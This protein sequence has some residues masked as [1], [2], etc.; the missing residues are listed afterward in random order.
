MPRTL[1]FSKEDI[2]KIAF[3]ILIEKGSKEI[4]ARNLAEK[5]GSSTISI[6]SNFSS[7][8]ELKNE[9]SKLAKNKLFQKVLINYTDIGLLNIGIGICLFAKE[10]K[11][12]FRAIFM[13]ENSSKEFQDELV[14]NLRSLVFDSFRNGSSYSF[15]EDET[16]E[17]MLKK[18]WWYVHGFAC[19]ICSGFYEPSYEMI[20][21]ELMENGSI[22][23]K[24]ALNFNK[25]L[26]K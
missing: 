16:I 18:G 7:M 17:W 26:K 19:L 3:D 8:G 4:T 14:N 24:E 11:A 20:E 25:N 2:L 15:F 13:R 6:Y 10:E 5:L 12:L 21:K 22:L 23:L 1:K 9:L